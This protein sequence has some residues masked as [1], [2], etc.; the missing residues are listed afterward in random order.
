MLHEVSIAGLTLDQA[1][2]TPILIL[3]NRQLVYSVS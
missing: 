3:K 1:T 2:N